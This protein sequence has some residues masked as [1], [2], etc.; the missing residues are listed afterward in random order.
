MKKSSIKT[1]HLFITALIIISAFVG[2]NRTKADSNADSNI[3]YTNLVSQ[4][5]QN[6]LSE[7]MT[8]AGISDKRRNILIEHNKQFNSYVNQTS[9]AA[10]FEEYSPGKTK[11]D[12]YDLQDEW[13]NKSPDFMGYNCRITAFSLF[14]EF[15]E[16]PA[17][18]EIRNEMILFDLCALSEDSSA[19]INND[20]EK[21][22]SVLYST[23]PTTLTKDTDVHV[24]ALQKDWNKR[25]IKFLDNEKASLISVVFHET[26]DEKDNYLFI[27]HTGV[28]FDYNDKIYFIEKI[29]FQEPYQLTEFESRSQL[30]DYLMSKYDVSFDQPT[31]APFIMEN[32]KLLEKY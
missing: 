31:A 19:L 30:N 22:F 25:E 2:C 16:I 7:I 8:Y 1:I 27:G 13:N 11:Y 14:G 23:V 15:L 17:T 5:A 20:D 4:N 18:S 28:L 29:A 24:K 12:P 3:V 6:K 26:I 21:A 9:L 32:D 10:E